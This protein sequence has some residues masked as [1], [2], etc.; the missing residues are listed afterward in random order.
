MMARGMRLQEAWVQSLDW[1]DPLEE[2]MATYSSILACRIPMNRE[3]GGLQSMGSQKVRCNE[4]EHSTEK[5][6]REK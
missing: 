4:T 3:A 2:G 5:M 1:D 6:E